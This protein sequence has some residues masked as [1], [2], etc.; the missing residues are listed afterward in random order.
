MQGINREVPEGLF[1]PKTAIVD[2]GVCACVHVASSPAWPAGAA[3]Y[4]RHFMKTIVVKNWERFQH[5]KDRDPPWV[6]LYRDM[7]TS[8]PWVLGTDVSRLVQVA[9]TLLA[10]RYQNA[11]PYQFALL[12]KVASFD[13]TEKQF[14]KAIDYLHSVDFLEIQGVNKDASTPL[15]SC[16]PGARAETEGEQRERQSRA[17]GETEQRQSRDRDMSSSKLPDV[18]RVFEHWKVTWEHPKAALDLKRTASIKRALSVYSA[19]DLCIAISGYRNS[20]HHTGQNDRQTVY[21]DI[22]LLLR[23]SA[24]IDAGIRFADKPQSLTSE[25]ANHNVAVLKN[26]TP[27][28]LRDDPARRPEISSDHGSAGGGVRKAAISGPH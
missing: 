18:G 2:S 23:D 4:L 5:Y 20:P 14:D 24:H 9:I 17:E 6:K 28:E 11:I 10:A 27:S 1:I 8:E 16:Y 12:K 3:A 25:L 13:F 7:L 15:A 21:D 26:W 22:G 19:D